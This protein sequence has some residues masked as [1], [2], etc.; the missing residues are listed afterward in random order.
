MYFSSAMTALASSDYAEAA[1]LLE[2]V[3]Y[4]YPESRLQ[5]KVRKI[6]KRLQ[7][8]LDAKASKQN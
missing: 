1:R 2:I 3:Q 6:Q 7:E 8:T 4:R 5:T